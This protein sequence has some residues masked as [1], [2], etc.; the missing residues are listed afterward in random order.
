MLYLYLI[1]FYITSLHIIIDIEQLNSN[2]N[3]IIYYTNFNSSV[4]S[5][6][7]KNLR[8]DFQDYKQL[9]RKHRVYNFLENLSNKL[10]S[11]SKI[12]FKNLELDE[13][14]TSIISVLNRINDKCERF[15]KKHNMYIY[16][17]IGL[18]DDSFGNVSQY[19]NSIIERY[20]CEEKQFK[21]E[22]KSDVYLDGVLLLSK[23][24]KKDKNSYRS[25]NSDRKSNRQTQDSSIINT[26]SK[27]DS[28][29]D[30]SSLDNNTN[31]NNESILTITDYNNS[32][33]NNIDNKVEIDMDEENKYSDSLMIICPPNLN[34]IE[35]LC[36]HSEDVNFYFKNDI[37]VLIYNYRGY[38]NSNSY[39]NIPRTQKDIVFIINEMRRNYS[40]KKIGIHGRSIGSI[41]ACYAAGKNLVDFCFVDRGFS[42][43]DDL[44]RSHYIKIIN[45]LYKLTFLPKDNNEFNFVKSQKP[46]LLSCDYNDE[47]IPDSSSLKTGIARQIVGFLREKGVINN[48]KNNKTV[49]LESILNIDCDLFINVII[50]VLSTLKKSYFKKKINKD[51]SKYNE[52]D[53]VDNNNNTPKINLNNNI[54]ITSTDNK[55]LTPKNNINNNFSSLNQSN[56]VS[57]LDNSNTTR[58][59]GCIDNN[60]TNLNTKE[61]NR[62]LSILNK[63]PQLKLDLSMINKENANTSEKKDNESIE[64]LDKEGKVNHSNINQMSSNSERNNYY[65]STEF[66]FSDENYSNSLS[67][68]ET[69]EKIKETIYKL[70]A[71]DK[72]LF[73]L[74]YDAKFEFFKKEVDDFF[75]NLLVWG[76]YNSGSKKINTRKDTAYKTLLKKMNIII[77]KL[78]RIQENSDSRYTLES[79]VLK[80]NLKLL[81]FYLKKFEETFHKIIFKNYEEVNN[82]YNFENNMSLSDDNIRNQ[83]K[84]ELEMLNDDDRND[85]SNNIKII[86]GD[87]PDN[88]DEENNDSKKNN[89]RDEKKLGKKKEDIYK[90]LELSDFI[91]NSNFGSL[92]PVSCGH[93]GD[94]YYSYGE[95]L[96]AH[97]IDN[98]FIE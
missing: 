87:I 68:E 93:N 72:T 50:V 73:D 97:L 70:D 76:S 83:R 88:N 41:P 80:D 32:N 5:S 27:S 45:F 61:N 48:D 90:Y 30:E 46:K 3:E 12:S 98:K 39:S 14:L 36:D 58:T 38:G 64:I 29:F 57:S 92:I 56:N 26:N 53:L 21:V 15:I 20:T 52:V 55:G 11:D 69:Y 16:Y 74:K 65:C 31:H 96:R 37:D 25:R 81:V 7:Q 35:L 60:N 79:K 22:E 78:K 77:C 34:N 63:K 75:C 95:A 85:N 71:A 40:Y 19:K 62:N 82:K 94:L 28:I 6:N 10:K 4:A 91:L 13:S 42:S 44:V 9:M 54:L 49:L 66:L 24:K 23:Y 51:L 47:T 84:N 89:G 67:E 1:N 33:L 2:I 59:L 86:D 18:D 8:K 17:L 43:V